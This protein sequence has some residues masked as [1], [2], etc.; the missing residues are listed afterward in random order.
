MVFEL[1][2]TYKMKAHPIYITSLSHR[3]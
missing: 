2:I 3:F 1:K